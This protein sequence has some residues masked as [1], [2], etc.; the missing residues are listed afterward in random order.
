[1]RPANFPTLRLAQLAML[2]H[3]SLHLFSAI[4]ECAGVKEITA[5]LKVMAND[6]WHYHYLLNEPSAF[7]QKHLG[8]Q[9]INNIL[10]NTVITMLF[11]WGHYHK[12]DHDTYKALRWLEEIAAENNAITKGFTDLGIANSTAFDSQALIQLKNE[13]CSKKRCLS[14]GVGNQILKTW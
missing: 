10:I 12:N 4:K 1:M 2:V 9:M 3:Q 5:L 11:S 8:I 6:Y 7:K 13:Y 14:C